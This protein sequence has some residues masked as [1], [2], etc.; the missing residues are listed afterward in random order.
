MSQTESNYTEKGKNYHFDFILFRSLI[1]WVVGRMI[2]HDVNVIHT[3][4]D[5]TKVG[6]SNAKQVPDGKKHPHTGE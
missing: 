5:S 2:R 4:L 1:E 3:L 6:S